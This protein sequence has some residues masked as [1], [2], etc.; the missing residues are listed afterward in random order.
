M[1]WRGLAENP[2]VKHLSWFLRRTPGGG[3]AIGLALIGLFA[4]FFHFEVYLRVPRLVWGPAVVI[5]LGLLFRWI[6]KPRVEDGEQAPFRNPSDGKK[7]ITWTREAQ[8]WMS[9][10][11][12]FLREKGDL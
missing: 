1:T 11:A 5:G 9:S 7:K 8:I 2:E 12:S 3:L 10:P 4:L 6:K